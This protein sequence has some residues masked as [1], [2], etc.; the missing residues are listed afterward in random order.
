MR[1]KEHIRLDTGEETILL[2]L[3]AD[4]KKIY[5]EVTTCCNFNCITCIRHS[6]S[7]EETSLSWHDFLSVVTQ[8][9]AFPDIQSVHFGGFGE[10]L[11]IQ[12]FQI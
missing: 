8:L 5:I 11:C 2:P 1:E 7:D 6:W 10:P 3:R 12:K 4:V 9:K